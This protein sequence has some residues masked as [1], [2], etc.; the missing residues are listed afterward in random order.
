M[1]IVS[2]EASTAEID[3][4]TVKKEEKRTWAIFFL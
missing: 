3:G 4:I 2:C 1:E